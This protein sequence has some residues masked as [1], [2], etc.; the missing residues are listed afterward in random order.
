MKRIVS[1]I[2][3]S[4][5]VLSVTGQQKNSRGEKLVSKLDISTYGIDIHNKIFDKS[6]ICYQYSGKTIVGAVCSMRSKVSYDEVYEVTLRNNKIYRTPYKLYYEYNLNKVGKVIN[7]KKRMRRGIYT[8]YDYV[9]DDKNRLVNLSVRDYFRNWF[10]EYVP[11]DV[12]HGWDIKWIDGNGYIDGYGM[13]F[14]DYDNDINVN[15]N[16]FLLLSVIDEVFGN[17]A[18]E[19]SIDWFGMRSDKLLEK[20][21]DSNCNYTI[22][23][24]F[25]EKKNLSEVNLFR[26][27]KDEQRLYRTIKVFY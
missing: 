12:A 24:I 3:L 26:I 14:S 15:L 4:F 1:V 6:Q 8:N 16:V 2:F 10:G 25:D 20:I 21:T 11:S 5:V 18:F 9:Y 7:K 13:E 17:E 27:V 22:K 19:H 23:Y